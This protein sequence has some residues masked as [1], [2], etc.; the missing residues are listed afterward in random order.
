MQ[1][2]SQAQSI[3]SL[4]SKGHF[5]EATKSQTQAISVSSF[6]EKH[7]NRA[8]L[9]LPNHG[10]VNF[11]PSL[12]SPSAAAPGP[13]AP[14]LP[15][16]A[17][18]RLCWYKSSLQ[19]RSQTPGICGQ[20][21]ELGL[22]V[23]GTGHIISLFSPEAV[24]ILCLTQVPVITLMTTKCTNDDRSESHTVLQSHLICSVCLLQCCSQQSRQRNNL[25]VC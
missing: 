22:L 20:S 5:G 7:L 10:G 6:Y 12:V 18:P 3:S 16:N 25:S 13:T 17:Q 21:S 2:F 19:D 11:L 8:Q 9:T 4:H 14:S 1:G 15:Y 23:C 24:F